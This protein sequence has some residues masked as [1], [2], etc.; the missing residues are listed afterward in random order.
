MSTPQFEQLA[1]AVRALTT[2]SALFNDA[3]AG[4]LGIS[5]SEL[6]VLTLLGD[7][8]PL[9]AGQLADQTQLTTGAITR[10]ID[11]LEQAGLVERRTDPTDR[12][13]V[14]VVTTAEIARVHAVFAP[15]LAEAAALA[16]RYTSEQLQ[17]ITAFLQESATMLEG[18]IR[19]PA[20]SDT[21][22]DGQVSAAVDGR[23]Q[24][25]LEFLAGAGATNV[26]VTPAVGDLL[27]RA[28]FDRAAPDI[29]VS[30]DTISVRGR[31][32]S[33]IELHPAVAWEVSMRGGSKDLSIDLSA[34]RVTGLS[35]TGGSN[36]AQFTLGTP[37]G[38]AMV[39]LGRGTNKV[40]ITRPDAVPVRVTARGGANKVTV[41][42]RTVRGD[43]W[44]SPG[45]ATATDRYDVFVGGGSSN[46]A[47]T[48]ARSSS[49]VGAVLRGLRGS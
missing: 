18:Q 21:G 29:R 20:A 45:W 6:V 13:R 42:G 5:P 19:P 16:A 33:L 38:T 15:M 37:V 8:G 36:K 49:A 23:T 4:R 43:S 44:E 48:R 25:R 7:G 28:R 27:F 11:R 34:G 3:A 46:I 40:R 9:T 12:R 32:A 1:R 35:L 14:M 41:D 24:A 17:V 39:A 2:K 30:G 47:V 26:V 10:V 22:A 31:R